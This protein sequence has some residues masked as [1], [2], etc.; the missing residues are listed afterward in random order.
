M[1]TLVECRRPLKKVPSGLR[2]CRRERSH[3]ERFRFFKH[4]NLSFI[5]CFLYSLSWRSSHVV[6]QHTSATDNYIDSLSTICSPVAH[7]L[8]QN[9]IFRGGPKC[10]SGRCVVIIDSID[11]DEATKQRDKVSN[12]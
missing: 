7:S 9:Q 4:K 12:E 11:R 1:S 10:V 6:P 2:A 3:S 8:V 5:V